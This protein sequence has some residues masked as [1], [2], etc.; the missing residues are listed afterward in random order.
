LTLKYPKGTSTILSPINLK[1]GFFKSLTDDKETAF[2]VVDGKVTH[3]FLGIDSLRKLGWYEKRSFHITLLA[4]IV[5]IF[6]TAIVE[7][8]FDSIARRMFTHRPPPPLPNRIARLIAWFMCVLNVVFIAGL[9]YVYYYYP[10]YEFRYGLPFVVKIILTIPMLSAL[11]TIIVFLFAKKAWKA[12]WW[13]G[14]G[15][16]HYSLVTLASLAFYWLI[17][18]WNLF[19]FWNWG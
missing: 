15:R 2:R 3:M 8:P 18:Y 13:G 17:C 7:W 19:G 10:Y 16:M 11:L 14:F 9:V 1:K 5:I 6:A 4:I 12:G